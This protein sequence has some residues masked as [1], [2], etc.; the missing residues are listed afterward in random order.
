MIANPLLGPGYLWRGM[1]MLGRPGLR[2]YVL[3]PLLLNLV[4]FGFL[5]GLSLAQF[6][7]WIEQLLGLL[8]TW[9]DFLRWL[10]WPIAV[11]LLLVVAAYL[12]SVV[13]NFIAAPFNGLLAERAEA[14]LTGRPAPD[15]GFLGLVADTPRVLGKELRKLLYYLPRALLVLIAS[16]LPP[17]YPFAP[18]LWF[19]LGA[20]MMALQYCDYPM[21][22]HRWPLAR[23]KR[24]L[25]GD[26]LTS[27][28]FGAAVMACTVVPLLNLL[29]MPAAVC[30]ATL[31]WIERLRPEV[32]PSNR[33]HNDGLN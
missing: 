17:L 2:R 9:L 29:V 33:L 14:L 16:L 25:A 3:V 30:G 20:W 1:Q 6:R 15:T 8:P 24:T 23:V 19:A 31:Y 5:I 4:I 18:L 22:N 27:L 28:G 13:A 21:D 32:N 7:D 10:L 12:F 11:L 26:R